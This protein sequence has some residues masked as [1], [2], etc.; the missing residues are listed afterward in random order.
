MLY[1]EAYERNGK[2]IEL[3]PFPDKEGY[4][5]LQFGTRGHELME[6]RYKEMQG[7][8]REPYPSSPIELLELEAQ[9]V[10]AG[11]YNKYAH[12]S[13]NIIDVEKSVCVPLNADHSFIGKM[14][15]VY[16]REDMDAKVYDILDHKFQSRSAKS[17]LPQKWAARDQATLYLWA[18]E[19]IYGVE[20]G[21][22]IVNAVTR[23]SEKGLVPPS[24]PDR[25]KLERTEEQKRLAVRDIIYIADQ[26]SEL[27]AKYGTKE[28]WPAS[29]ENC[30]TWGQCEFYAIHTW[31]TDAD[32]IINEK[33][34]PKTPYLFL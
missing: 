26:I 23:P 28:S 16:Q 29:R 14:D 17:N 13:M 30:Y 1:F 18:A 6:E 12:E 11:Y 22:F 15:L 7:N 2:G 31:G 19:Q 27:R 24:Y 34:Q 8:P 25:Q 4:S 10:M 3:K 9:M 21:N 33:Y 20:I 5:P 32:V